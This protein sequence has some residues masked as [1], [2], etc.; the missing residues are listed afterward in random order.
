MTVQLTI[1]LLRHGETEWNVK[2]RP[3][4]RMDSPLTELGWEQAAR[5]AD[6]LSGIPF[7]RAYT[8]PLG[9]ARLSAER[10]LAGRGVALNVLG[11]VWLKFQSQR[12]MQATCTAAK[13][14]CPRFS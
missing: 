1:Y 10:V 8:S 6:Q 11:S 9:R 2:Q 5:Y 4:G 12:M 13:N 3:Q 14:W 7:V